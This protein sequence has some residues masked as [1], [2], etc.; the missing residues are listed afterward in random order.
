MNFYE[1]YF[2]LCIFFF[3]NYYFYSRFHSH[4]I[5][6]KIF[7]FI[8]IFKIFFLFFGIFFFLC[9]FFSS[10]I[11]LKFSFI[12][13]FLINYLN[14]KDAFFSLL[15][16]KFIIFIFQSVIYFSV[17]HITIRIFHFIN[18]PYFL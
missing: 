4:L 14:S 15:L 8:T 3:Q 13:N 1:S 2:L 11:F 5:F 9:Y 12:M 10:S 17:Y 18:F 16:K 6:F 7:I